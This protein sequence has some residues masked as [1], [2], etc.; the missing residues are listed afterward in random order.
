M[1]SVNTVF[2]PSVFMY[3]NVLEIWIAISHSRI[4]DPI[5]YA[6][7]GARW[8]THCNCRVAINQTVSASSLLMQFDFYKWR[9]CLCLIT[10]DT[11]HCSVKL[12]YS[13]LEMLNASL[14]VHFSDFSDEIKPTRYYYCNFYNFKS[15]MRP[16]LLTFCHVVP[17]IL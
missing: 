13:K 17:H 3:V 9:F 15:V 5:F 14:P 4:F 12:V 16:I 11:T 10:A 7:A 1:F 6:T 2:L 8:C